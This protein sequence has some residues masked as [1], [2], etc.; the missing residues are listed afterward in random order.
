[1]RNDLWL[2]V[3]KGNKNAFLSFYE[4]NYQG[5]FSYGYRLCGNKD[6]VKDCIQELFFELW[7]SRHTTNIEVKNIQSYLMTWL[8][9]IISRQINLLSKQH[10]SVLNANYTENEFSYEE[11]LVQL[12][13]DDEKKKNLEE[14]L[15][16][17]SPGQLKI[18]RLKYFENKTIKEIADENDLAKQTVYNMI[19]KALVVLRHAMREFS[20]AFMPFVLPVTI[21][22]SS[23]R[24]V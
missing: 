15:L 8:R 10:H 23:H 1:M 9:R 21:M 4:D 14:A 20:V 24:P 16:K 2:S 22:L 17:L 19:Y 11:L 6:L 3:L 18:I 5:L 13:T 7:K 12:Q